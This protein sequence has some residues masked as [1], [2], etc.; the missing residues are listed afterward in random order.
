MER[1]Q[2]GRMRWLAK[3]L[4]ESNPSGGSN[5]PFSVRPKI[6]PGTKISAARFVVFL[7]A[8]LLCSGC[9]K[10][11]FIIRSSPCE[12]RVFLDGIELEN[13]AGLIEQRFTFHGTR[14]LVVRSRGYQTKAQLWTLEPPWYSKFP[15]DFFTELL[16]P[17][18]IEEEQEITVSLE[19][20][21]RR[22]VTESEDLVKRAEEL[23]KESGTELR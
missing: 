7:F 12:A 10:R 22:D 5:P 8:L 18:T 6:A 14:S 4:M 13:K 9:I 19:R 16:I 1:W 15:I 11:K 23:A 3:P 21:P 2:S 20:A 17:W